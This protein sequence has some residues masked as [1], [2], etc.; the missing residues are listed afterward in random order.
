VTLGIP[1]LREIVITASK[2]IGTP[3]MKLPIKAGVSLERTDMMVKRLNKVMLTQVLEKIS[4]EE[5]MV[6][7]VSFCLINVL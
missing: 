1:R 5:K 7:N 4:I 6:G 2:K 3:M